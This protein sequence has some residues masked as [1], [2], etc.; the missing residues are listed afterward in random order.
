MGEMWSQISLQS[1][2]LRR[3]QVVQLGLELEIIYCET[4]IKDTK[5]SEY[6]GGGKEWSWNCVCVCAFAHLHV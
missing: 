6:E 3:P 4:L 2:D 1:R 5:C